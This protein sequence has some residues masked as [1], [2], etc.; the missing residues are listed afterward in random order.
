MKCSRLA[1]DFKNAIRNGVLI[2]GKWECKVCGKLASQHPV[3]RSAKSTSSK[4][5]EWTE[6]KSKSKAKDIGVWS[7]NETLCLKSERVFS[8]KEAKGI[9]HFSNPLYPRLVTESPLDE[10]N[11]NILRAF[12][13]ANSDPNELET[14]LEMTSPRLIELIGLVAFQKLL[15]EFGADAVR[16][17]K[18][19]KV[20][21]HLTTPHSIALHVDFSDKT[22][23][24][25]LNSPTEFEGGEIVFV[26]DDGTIQCPKRS[27]GS[28]LLHD[29]TWAHGVTALTSGTRYHLFFLA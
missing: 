28:M 11:C 14:I 23:S 15:S 27:K 7:V 20:T 21:A 6:T 13:D 25:L 19:R 10:T 29:N 8:V 4:L 2:N 26:H 12:L 22:M 1:Q 18:L 17:V 3:G 9:D 16:Q 5:G 24:V